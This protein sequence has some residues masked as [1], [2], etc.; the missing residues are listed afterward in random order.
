MLDSIF[1]EGSTMTLT[2]SNFLLSFAISLALGFVIAGLY[3]FRSHYSKSFVMT[4]VMLPAVVQVVILLV[5]GNLGVGVAVAGTFSLVRFRSVPGTAREITSIF[6]AMAVG[7]AAGMGYLGIAVLLV[8]VLGAV[9]MILT[10]TSFGDQRN[11]KDLRITIPESLNYTDVF[12]DI[13]KSY[14]KNW[15]LVQVKT[16]NMGSLYKLTYQIEMK[17]TSEEKKMIDELRCCNG[18]LEISCMT[19]SFGKEEL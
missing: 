6:L 12:D 14:A 13:L 17:D 5:N 16:T 7:L 2:A 15:E 19:S 3:M 18:N 9:S 8:V 1:L 4:L 10:I 11:R